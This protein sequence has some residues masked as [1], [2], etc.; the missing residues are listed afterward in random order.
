MLSVEQV[1]LLHVPPHRSQPPAHAFRSVA[2]PGWLTEKHD[3]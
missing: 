2:C 1:P 3:P